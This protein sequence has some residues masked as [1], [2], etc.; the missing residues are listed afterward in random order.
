[1]KATELEIR[2]IVN[3]LLDTDEQVS[4]HFASRF[5]LY[6][7]IS[8]NLRKRGLENPSF[9]VV[10]QIVDEELA[11]RKELGYVNASDMMNEYGG[12][13]SKH[14]QG[15]GG[16]AS[17]LFVPIKKFWIIIL[18]FLIYLAIMKEEILHGISQTST[19]EVITSIFIYIII[20]YVIYIKIKRKPKL[21]IEDQKELN[22][23]N[24]H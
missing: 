11:Q 4:G 12:V 21:S 14:Q 8:A 22:D 1:M 10:S 3:M 5:I 24:L 13:E 2:A 15:C 20:I 17:I 16:C 9:G 7:K 23:Q 18:I 19:L 6:T